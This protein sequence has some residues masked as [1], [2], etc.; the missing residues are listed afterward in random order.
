MTLASLLS[1]PIVSS[2]L[3]FDASARGSIVAACISGLTPLEFWKLGCVA[4]FTVDFSQYATVERSFFSTV[5]DRR[6]L[7]TNLEE[8]IVEYSLKHPH[9]K[10]PVEICVTF[11]KSSMVPKPII[12]D[13]DMI[14]VNRMGMYIFSNDSEILTRVPV[15]LGILIQNC[16]DKKFTV[17]AKADDDVSV[18]KKQKDLAAFGFEL[19]QTRIHRAENIPEDNC[20]ICQ[21]EFENDDAVRTEC[22]HFFHKQCWQKH[23]EHSIEKGISQLPSSFSFS[24]SSFLNQKAGSIYIH[25]P[26]CRDSYRAYEVVI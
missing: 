18:L 9:A 1:D 25:C 24:A 14:A 19:R 12:V 11:N 16:Q 13:T 2:L 22:G 7:N 8:R 26:M 5:E 10:D 4:E 23:T 15:P 3:S 21:Q 20:P 17:L 6:P